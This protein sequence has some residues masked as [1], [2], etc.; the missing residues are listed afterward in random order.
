M[1]K[2]VFRS[3][4]A[5]WYDLGNGELM[6]SYALTHLIRPLIKLVPAC[7]L[8]L[9]GGPSDNSFM[10]VWVILCAIQSVTFNFGFMSFPVSKIL[11]FL[12]S[13]FDF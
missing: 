2:W 12:T 8:E 5:A 10:V 13:F 9:K 3:C 7:H 4:L 6:V 1:F 11:E